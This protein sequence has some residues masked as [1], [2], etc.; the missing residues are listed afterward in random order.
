MPGGIR[1]ISPFGNLTFSSSN[2]RFAYTDLFGNQSV[3][4]SEVIIKVGAAYA[5]PT[6]PVYQV[7][8]LAFSEAYQL[9]S[10]GQNCGVLTVSLNASS[11]KMGFEFATTGNCGSNFNVF[12]L[13]VGSGN[14]CSVSQTG[15]PTYANSTSTLTSLGNV[16]QGFLQPNAAGTGV[17]ASVNFADYGTADFRCGTMTI[18]GTN[19]HGAAV[20]FPQ[21]VTTVDPSIVQYTSSFSSS[22]SDSCTYSSNVTSG[23]LLIVTAGAGTYVTISD[24]LSLSWSDYS[25]YNS[26]QGMYSWVYFA[27]VSTGGSETVTFSITYYGAFFMNCYELSGLSTTVDGEST[28]SGSC[29][30]CAAVATVT[31]YTPPSGDFVFASAL[32]LGVNNGGCGSTPYWTASSGYTLTPVNNCNGPYSPSGL[33]GEEYQSSAGGS[34]TTSKITSKLT[35]GAGTATWWDISIAFVPRVTQ[36]ITATLNTAYG[37][38]TQTVSVSGCSPSPSTFPGD[39]SS[40]NIIMDHSCSYS[41]TLPSGYQWTTSSSSTSC[42]SGTCSSF[43]A[44]YERS[45]VNQPITATLSGDASGL[46]PLPTP[47]VTISG[48]SAYPSSFPGDGSQYYITAEPLCTLNVGSPAGYMWEDGST[49]TTVSTC[50]SGTCYPP[51][52]LTLVKISSD[53]NVPMGMPSDECIAQDNPSILIDFNASMITNGTNG[54][55][56]SAQFNS[57]P[58]AETTGYNTPSLDWMQF[59]MAIHGNNSIYGEAQF[60]TTS[61]T[62]VYTNTSST[63]FTLP[64]GAHIESG[65]QFTINI[66]QND[67]THEG[68]WAVQYYYYDSANSHSYTQYITDIPSTYFVPISSWQLNFVGENSG[69]NSHADFSSG[70]ANVDYYSLAN[71]TMWQGTQP[72]CVQAHFDYL[73]PIITQETSNMVYS[74][75]TESG[76]PTDVF[77]GV[78]K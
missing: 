72:P 32:Q 29:Y 66:F 65:D 21:N 4:D 55:Q 36:P 6:T 38:S 42:S 25:L 41:V 78:E 26:V 51:S 11:W 3:K 27:Q 61:P 62:P 19:L 48:C 9:V 2:A 10:G 76:S 68:V 47:T 34:A 58:V 56:W 20:I 17:G 16:T 44:T 59:T 12:W 30:L 75:P 7:S 5:V 1:Y 39:S 23:D 15:Q 64:S 60:W 74:V 70:G 28:G 40:N 57:L 14:Y 37:G 35:P 52:S 45:P 77:Q 8:P 50:T 71:N 67:S 13:L 18:G 33:L 63:L 22:N 73:Y 54:E 46:S 43:S 53:V 24:R 49:S 31:S 69:S